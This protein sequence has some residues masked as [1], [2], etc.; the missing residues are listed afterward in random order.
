VGIF[1]GSFWYA[2]TLGEKGGW[3]HASC[4]GKKAPRSKRGEQALQ[5]GVTAN[6]VR[7]K[8]EDSTK[9]RQQMPAGLMAECRSGF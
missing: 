5:S 3:V 9:K 2:A 7:L 4:P 8:P 1:G 6:C